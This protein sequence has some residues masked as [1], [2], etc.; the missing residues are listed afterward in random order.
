M[1]REQGRTL[2]ELAASP[3]K[4][5]ANF[6]LFGV[7]KETG[8]DDEGLVDFS[9][10]NFNFPLYRDQSLAFYQDFFNGR[11]LGLTTWNPIRLYKGYKTMNSRLAEKK[12]EGNLI[13]EGMVQGGI[14]IFGTDGKARYAY[15]EETG[16]DLPVDDILAAVRAVEEEK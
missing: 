6:R 2:T 10:Q 12:L 8:V 9:S 3:S 1:C 13:G 14:I 16:K 4:P 5:L 11:K 7:V 15:E